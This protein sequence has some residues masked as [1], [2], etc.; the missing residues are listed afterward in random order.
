MALAVSHR[1]GLDFENPGKDRD[2][3]TF[4]QTREIRQLAAVTVPTRQ[5]Q[6]QILNAVVAER[7]PKRLGGS[8]AH[9]IDKAGR[10]LQTFSHVG[11]CGGSG[12]G[13]GAATARVDRTTPVQ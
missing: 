10:E 3:F 4:S 13:F 1:P 12:A 9:G 6:Q 11:H 7:L 8:I 2:V 5:V